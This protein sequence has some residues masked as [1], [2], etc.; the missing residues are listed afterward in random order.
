MKMTKCLYLL[1]LILLFFCGVATTQTNS[2][3]TTAPC[4]PCE[5]LKE[6]DLPDVKIT[7]ASLTDDPVPHCKLLGVIGKE[8]HFELLLPDSWNVRFL[9]GGNGGFAGTFMDFLGNRGQVTKGYAIALTD[10]GHQGSIWEADWALGNA[11][12]QVNFGHLSVHRTAVVAKAI[13]KQFYC[14]AP[15]YSYFYGCSKGGGQGMIAAQRYPGDFDGIVAAAP[16]VDWAE[17]AAAFIHHGKVMYPDPEHP[18]QALITTSQLKLLQAAILEQCDQIDG[19]TD[20]ILQDPTAC[21]FDFD[22]LPQCTGQQATDNC[23]T[24]AQITGLKKVY[25]GFR[26]E[27]K[28]IHPGFPFGCE[29]T[30]PFFIVDP[31]AQVMETLGFPTRLYRLG[32]DVF[33]YLIFQDPDW[34]YRNYD[35]SNLHADTRY[36]AAYLNATSTDY[37]P[38][39]DAGGKMILFHGWTDPGQSAFTTIDHYEA[40]KKEDP[41][42][43]DYFRLFLLPGVAHCGGGPGPSEADWVEL[44]RAWVEQGIAPKRVVLSKTEDGEVSMTRPVF[45]YPKKAEYDGKGD[46][47]KESSFN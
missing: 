20:G 44:V 41:Q 16:A 46:P 27:D 24:S 47:N 10:T 2:S 8:I 5:E 32:V 36:A 39:R 37:K 40:A 42:L 13:I 12:R 38:F 28:R 4:L 21:T 33:R 1:V 18:D 3:P 35:F 19:I 14:Q 34:D 25:E 9:M 23:F 43:A 30:W 11:E 45:P 31:D 22:L 7:G 15:A 26:V 17:F 6:L 29:E